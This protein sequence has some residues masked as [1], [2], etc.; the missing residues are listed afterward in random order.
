MVQ[1][2]FI[3]ELFRIFE[4]SLNYQLIIFDVNINLYMTGLDYNE[5]NQLMN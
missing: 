1:I 3:N 2:M 4:R 5:N